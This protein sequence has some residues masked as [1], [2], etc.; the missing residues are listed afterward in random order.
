MF[1]QSVDTCGWIRPGFQPTEGDPAAESASEDIDKVW[2]LT[3]HAH[4]VAYVSNNFEVVTG[5]TIRS[6]CER[7]DSWRDLLHPDD[8]QRLLAAERDIEKRKDFVTTYRFR[9]VDGAYYPGRLSVQPIAF[10]DDVSVAWFWQLRIS[11][12]PMNNPGGEVH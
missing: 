4:A 3:T 1:D 12:S 9:R 6:L 11:R 8:E 7:P 2:W 5:L 10:D